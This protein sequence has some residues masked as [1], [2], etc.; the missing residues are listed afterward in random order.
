MV[1]EFES[2]INEDLELIAKRSP[3]Q[4]N[5]NEWLT[6]NCKSVKRE[7]NICKKL[8]SWPPQK[9]PS[10]LTLAQRPEESV[11]FSGG[12]W[13]WWCRFVPSLVCAVSF[14]VRSH[15]CPKHLCVK[16]PR[17]SK[18]TSPRDC[19]KNGRVWPTN[20]PNHQGPK[21]WGRKLAT[22]FCLLGAFCCWNSASQLKKSL[23][24]SKEQDLFRD[25]KLWSSLLSEQIQSLDD[26]WF[27]MF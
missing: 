20:T 1:L 18:V 19:P 11:D 4:Q 16:K 15:L 21:L 7:C 8:V 6:L 22:S 27:K 9:Y 3:E 12:A 23:T 2:P 26:T 13:T 5:C 14:L 25:I 24:K 17:L 10:T